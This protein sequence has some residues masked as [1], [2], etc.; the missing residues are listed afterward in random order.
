MQN[1][2]KAHLLSSKVPVVLAELEKD[3]LLETE[4][5]FRKAPLKV[6]D[7]RNNAV[8]NCVC[9]NGFV[10]FNGSLK[11]DIFY[12]GFLDWQV[13]Y[14]PHEVKIEG[15]LA[16]ALIKPNMIAYARVEIPPGCL[17]GCIEDSA[18]Y[19]ESIV[20]NIKFKICRYEMIHSSLLISG[21]HE[22]PEYYVNYPQ[23]YKTPQS[24]LQGE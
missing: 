24:S 12:I 17:K 4:L 9:C 14:A 7:I 19:R 21:D 1:T 22:F 2:G 13:Y 15:F 16:D 5:E 18:L 11:Q 8:V 20:I 3:L 23:E 10:S 6:C